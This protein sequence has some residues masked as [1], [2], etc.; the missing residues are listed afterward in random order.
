MSTFKFEILR[1]FD[2][3]VKSVCLFVSIFF[4][5]CDVSMV[6][7]SFSM[8]TL[9]FELSILSVAGASHVICSTDETAQGLETTCIWPSICVLLSIESYWFDRHTYISLSPLCDL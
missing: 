8:L 6:K 9:H 2:K 7:G 1:P 3:N 5:A 4:E